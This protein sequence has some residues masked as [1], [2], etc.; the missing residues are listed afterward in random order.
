VP[1]LPGVG[2]ET[3]TSPIKEGEVRPAIS[4][5]SKKVKHPLGIACQ[6]GAKL[7]VQKP[8]FGRRH[9]IEARNLRDEARA[10]CKSVQGGRKEKRKTAG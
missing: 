8:E 3:S 5:F 2:S 10:N 6:G 4:W 1:G 7:K 9:M